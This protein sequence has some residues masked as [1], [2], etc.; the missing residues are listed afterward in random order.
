M[1]LR[2][3]A[4]AALAAVLTL[5]AGASAAPKSRRVSCNLITDARGDQQVATANGYP[6]KGEPWSS[7]FDL[8]S[9]DLATSKNDATAVIRLATVRDTLADPTS[10]AHQYWL[11]FATGTTKFTMA[12][13]FGP[14]GQSGYAFT[15]AGFTGD[16]GTAGVAVAEGI[17]DLSVSVDRDR[18]EIRMTGPLSLFAPYA[19]LAPGKTVRVFR[20]WSF[21][22]DGP[23]GSRVQPVPG[24]PAFGVGGGGVSSGT[25]RADSKATYV[26]GSRSCVVVGK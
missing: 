2:T 9:A 3:P 21:Q 1:S 16:E 6:V 8:L 20:A 24:G 11:E 17:G 5:A 10:P 12:A 18:G 4:Y 26:T 22:H 14:D 13:Y 25:D 19:S 7:D 15:E 23:A